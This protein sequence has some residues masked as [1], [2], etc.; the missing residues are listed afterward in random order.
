MCVCLCVC[1]CVC[2]CVCVCLCLCGRFTVNSV[3][4]LW[5]D[6]GDE[7]QLIRRSDKK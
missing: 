6:D 7:F 3:V 4:L 1:V 5:K 2:E